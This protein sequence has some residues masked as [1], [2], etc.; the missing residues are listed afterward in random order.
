MFFYEALA[1]MFRGLR[2]RPVAS[3][4]VDVDGALDA[5]FTTLVSNTRDANPMDRSANANMKKVNCV[6][7]A[8][9]KS[10]PYNAQIGRA[11]V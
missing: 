9:N 11:H 2:A 10:H 8:Y 6:V 4:S 1:R 3:Q 5:R 7:F